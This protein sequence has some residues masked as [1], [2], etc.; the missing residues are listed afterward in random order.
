MAN[1]PESGDRQE[2]Q[3]GEPEYRPLTPEFLAWACQGLNEEEIVAEL[4]EIRATGGLQLADFIQE[5]E[6][7]AMPHE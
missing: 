4:R 3:P 6:Q 5:I 2:R 7:E 1:D